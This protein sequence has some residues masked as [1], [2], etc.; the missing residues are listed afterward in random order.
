[1]PSTTARL[2]IFL[3]LPLLLPAVAAA[4]LKVA[5]LHPL[6]GDLAENIG[7]EHVTVV[8]LL[9]PGADPHA[10]TPTPGDLARCADARLIL[11]SGKGLEP[12]LDKIR[13]NLQPGQQVYEVGRKVPSLRIEVGAVFACCPSHSH[14]AIDP[15]WWHSIAN[16]QRAGR[17]LAEEF[18]RIDPAHAAAY[19][20]NARAWDKQLDALQSWAKKE[21]ARI[22]RGDRKLVTAHAAFGYLC[23]DFGLKSIPVQ[24]LNRE[25]DPSPQYLAETIRTLRREQARAIFPEVFANPKVLAAMVRESGVQVA[26]EALIAD[27]VGTGESATYDG[28]MRHNVNAI[29]RA[30]A[31][32][33]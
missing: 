3:L 32:V 31:I 7:G 11:A 6:L 13:D 28:M 12:Y 21:I 5:T 23:R 22:P 16:M 20:A 26:T 25:R 19:K 27:G 17:Y 14:G 8:P 24:G 2:A 1:M 9:G 18:T 10:F 15:H 4:Q 33:P 30:L 29:V